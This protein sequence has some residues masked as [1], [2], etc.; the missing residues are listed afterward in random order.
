MQTSPASRLRGIQKL[1]QVSGKRRRHKSWSL[2]ASG[3]CWSPCA[4]ETESFVISIEIHSNTRHYTKTYIPKTTMRKRTRQIGGAHLLYATRSR[5]R[6]RR[7]TNLTNLRCGRR[8]ICRMDLD[9]KD[10]QW[11]TS[12]I[13][14]KCSLTCRCMPCLPPTGIATRHSPCG[15]IRSH[16]E[17]SR[18]LQYQQSLR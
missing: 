11:S 6:A 3:S 10:N 1:G 8:P 15:C 9:Q 13:L 12:R 2:R 16:Y 17:R 18:G 14:P 7:R 5:H 4:M